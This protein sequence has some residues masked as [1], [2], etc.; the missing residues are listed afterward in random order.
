MP[1]AWA[2]VPIL[3]AV[4][5]SAPVTAKSIMPR[6][7]RIADEESEIEANG[8][9]SCLEHIYDQHAR[10]KARSPV[11]S[12]LFRERPGVDAIDDVVDGADGMIR[13]DKLVRQRWNQHKPMLMAGLENYSAMRFFPN[14]LKNKAQY[15]RAPY[16]GG[17][18]A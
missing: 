12:Q 9:P 1:T 5:R 4:K 17:S 8:M 6:D 2:Q 13:F 14:N 11:A 16:S 10:I 7:I 18:F 3:L 15:K